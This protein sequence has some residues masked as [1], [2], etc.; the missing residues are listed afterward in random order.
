MFIKKF[1][2]VL[3]YYMMLS[4]SSFGG[5]LYQKFGVF[6]FKHENETDAYALTTKYIQDKEVS[7]GLINALK[8]I[9]E[10]SFYYDDHHKDNQGYGAYVSSGLSKKIN[11]TSSL[12]LL[13]SFSAG[14][15][16]EFDE[17]KKMGYPLEFKSEVEL[18]FKILNSSVIGVSYSHISNADIG[19]KNP[20]SDNILFNLKLSENF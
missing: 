16:Q 11:L 8:P 20:G 9:Y 12:F 2:L 7:F 10:L 14:L 18:N 19:D 13:P 4:N 6:D 5:E 17:G 15:Y 3:L 1:I